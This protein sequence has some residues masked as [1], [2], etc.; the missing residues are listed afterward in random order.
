MLIKLLRA[1][2][3]TKCPTV[4]VV[5]LDGH[6]LSLVLADIAIF[7]ID[8]QRNLKHRLGRQ[9]GGRYGSD[10]M[11]SAKLSILARFCSCCCNFGQSFLSLGSLPVILL[12]AILSHFPMNFNHFYVATPCATVST[13]VTQSNMLLK[14][15]VGARVLQTTTT[16][17]TSTFRNCCSHQ[18]FWPCSEIVITNMDLPIFEYVVISNARARF[19]PTT[20]TPWTSQVHNCCSHHWFWLCFE[21]FINISLGFSLVLDATL[22]PWNL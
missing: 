13:I 14:P 15:L 9:V 3:L 7:R 22:A 1:R 10:Y 2:K 6:V 8:R 21:M 19:L 11:L 5:T 12:W 16:P 4:V 18:W 17:W 20:R